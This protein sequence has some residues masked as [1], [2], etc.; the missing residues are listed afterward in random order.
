MS[1]SQVASRGCPRPPAHRGGLCARIA[2]EHRAWGAG[3]DVLEP[4]REGK[5][6]AGEEGDECGCF[7]AGEGGEQCEVRGIEIGE[8]TFSSLDSREE[9]TLLHCYVSNYYRASSWWQPLRHDAVLRFFQLDKVN[10]LRYDIRYSY[11]LGLAIVERC[12]SKVFSD[13]TV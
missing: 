9:V 1:K 8:S 12:D 6:E 4:R 2:A 5:G 7:S 3:V 11:L 13:S 10:P